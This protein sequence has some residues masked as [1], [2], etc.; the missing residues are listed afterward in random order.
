MD[1]HTKHEDIVFLLQELSQESSL[2]YLE[3]AVDMKL[4][5]LEWDDNYAFEKRCIRA[6]FYIGKEKSREFLKKMTLSENEELR[7]LAVRKFN[8]LNSENK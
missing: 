4:A 5:Y 6:V 1:W 8:E 7:K 2:S 3:K